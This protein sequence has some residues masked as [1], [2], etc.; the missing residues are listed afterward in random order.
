[1]ARWGISSMESTG[2]SYMEPGVIMRV[3]YPELGVFETYD[4]AKKN[5][6]CIGNIYDNNYLPWLIE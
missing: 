3:I 1:M 4:E 5:A 2:S 6:E